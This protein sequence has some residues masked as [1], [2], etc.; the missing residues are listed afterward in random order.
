MN[1]K[2]VNTQNG[3]AI[4]LLTEVAPKRSAWAGKTCYSVVR[5][6]PDNKYVTLHVTRDYEEA[7]A[8][9]NRE[10]AA[11]KRTAA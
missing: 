10:W 4:G 8:L 3:W 2:I 9:A 6:A 1:A 11:D 5:I 7:R